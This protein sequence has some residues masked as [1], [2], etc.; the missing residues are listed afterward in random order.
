[1]QGGPSYFV[2]P[3]WWFEV[4]ERFDVPAHEPASLYEILLQFRY[5]AVHRSPDNELEPACPRVN[6]KLAHLPDLEGKRVHLF[7]TEDIPETR[8]GLL[9]HPVVRP[10][11]D[12]V[13]AQDVTLL[14]NPS[15]IIIIAI[16]G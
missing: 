13:Q 12:L 6:E 11:S 15:I 14:S 10:L 16:V 4:K 5:L 3:H 9:A 2:I 7:L 1:L 8:L